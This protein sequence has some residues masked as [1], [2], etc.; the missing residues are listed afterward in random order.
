MAQ[1][2]RVLTRREYDA[3][4]DRGEF[5]DKAPLE[6]LFGRLVPIVGEG[7]EHVAVVQALV[8]LLA[9][10]VPELLRLGHPL[11]ATDDSEPEPDLALASTHPHAH[12]KTAALVV[13]VVVSRR[14]QARDKAPI[15]A[16]AGVPA[17][18]IVDVPR[19]EVAVLTEPGPEGYGREDV[20]RGDDGLRVDVADLT[21]TVAELFARA[22]L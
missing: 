3:M 21:T 9:P 4:V 19:R 15:Y 2:E 12:P 13:E 6:L 10:R 5:G 18:W 11:A 17:Y 16:Q 22:G 8:V 1:A 7:P 20:R 14:R